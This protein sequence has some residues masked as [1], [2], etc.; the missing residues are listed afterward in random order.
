MEAPKS[1]S[2]LQG[3]ELLRVVGTDGTRTQITFNVGF[4][5]MYIRMKRI[6]C[7]VHAFVIESTGTVDCGELKK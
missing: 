7:K 4:N 1:T 2:Y 6:C 5:C 3:V